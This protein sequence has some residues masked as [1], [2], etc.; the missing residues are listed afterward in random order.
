[1]Q[2]HV[3]LLNAKKISVEVKPLDTVET[4]KKAISQATGLPVAVQCLS[5]NGVQIDRRSICLGDL[6][7]S[8][9]LINLQLAYKQQNSISSFYVNAVTGTGRVLTVNLEEGQSSSIRTLRKQLSTMLGI[10]EDSLFLRLVDSSCYVNKCLGTLF[11]SL[12]E[13]GVNRGSVVYV[14]IHPWEEK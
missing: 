2:V 1:M 6:I 8:K 11:N 3:N 12:E 4:L 14:Q 7:K 10:P 9:S 5:Q 13:C